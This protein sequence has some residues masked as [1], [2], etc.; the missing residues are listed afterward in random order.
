MGNIIY[1]AEELEQIINA[2]D[3]WWPNIEPKE[4]L[5]IIF[6]TRASGPDAPTVVRILLMRQ[7]LL[8]IF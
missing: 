2:I 4:A 8:L 3:K 7:I 6:S 1:S 5:S